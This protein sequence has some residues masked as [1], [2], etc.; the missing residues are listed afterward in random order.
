MTIVPLYLFPITIAI[1]SGIINLSASLFVKLIQ[2][3]GI[4]WL[5]HDQSQWELERRGEINM[6][7]KLMGWIYQN[8]EANMVANWLWSWWE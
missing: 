8:T 2:L 5:F 6:N 1:D 3:A 4:D 7:D